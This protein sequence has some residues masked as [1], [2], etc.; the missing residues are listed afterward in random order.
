MGNNAE[1]RKITEFVIKNA[2][3]P[4]ILDADGINSVSDNI[5]ILKERK[6]E[7]ILTPHPLEFSRISGLSVAE[8][9]RGRIEAARRFADRYGATVV[10][11]GA[12]T[13]IASPTEIYVNT[14]GNAGLAK[15]VYCHGLAADIAARE[16]TREYM[17]A[18]DVI[19]ALR[20]VYR[21]SE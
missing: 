11:K 16:L 13:V 5:D 18:G 6:D 14:T 9:Q 15:G 4:I 7:I 1:T 21:S 20:E 19:A 17:L 10:L 2:V 12:Y 8:I 3:C